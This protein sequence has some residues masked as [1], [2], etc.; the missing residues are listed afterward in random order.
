MRN[1]TRYA[2]SLFP[3]GITDLGC[4]GDWVGRRDISEIIV[5]PSWPSITHS[6]EWLESLRRSCLSDTRAIRLASIKRLARQVGICGVSSGYT[7][8]GAVCAYGAAEEVGDV[9]L[10]DCCQ[11]GVLAVTWFAISLSRDEVCIAKMLGSETSSNIANH[12]LPLR[13]KR[14]PH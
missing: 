2:V 5:S 9:P 8:G 3:S 1:Y 7:E 4:V 13:R 12:H 11:L 10:D 14:V 6:D